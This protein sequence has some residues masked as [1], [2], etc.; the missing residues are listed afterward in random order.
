MQ[1]QARAREW[2]FQG[3]SKTFGRVSLLHN[4][5]SK[6]AV[7][8]KPSY[9]HNNLHI[10]ITHFAQHSLSLCVNRST[11]FPP[12]ASSSSRALERKIIIKAHSRRGEG[13]AHFAQGGAPYEIMRGKNET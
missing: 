3:V 13:A 2:C 6:F 8:Q 7:F 10:E 5:F 11:I 12:F 1:L 9:K 4:P